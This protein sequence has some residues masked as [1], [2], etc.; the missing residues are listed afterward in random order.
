MKN[1]RWKKVF[2]YSYFTVLHLLAIVAV[3]L[4]G[5]AVAAKLKWTNVSGN[6]D[7][8][9][10]YFAKTANKYG[11]N[12]ATDSVTTAKRTSL[13]YQSIGVL[14]KYYPYNARV[15]IEEY[16]RSKNPTIAL[17]MLDAINLKLKGDKAYQAEMA[18][19]KSVTGKTAKSAFPWVNNDQWKTFRK[20]IKTDKKTI[21]SVSYITGVESRL[22][23]MCL[24]GE[25]VRMF[26]SKRE[27]FKQL[28]V[29]FNRVLLDKDRGYGVTGILASTA[30]NIERN[31]YNKK[32]PFYAGDYY[33]QCL[34]I[35][36]SVP[37]TSEKDSLNFQ[38]YYTIKRLTIGGHHYF[39]Y[40]YAALFLRQF[41]TQWLNAGYNLAYRPEVVA[42]LYNLGY[43]KSKP[44]P[45]PQVGGS[46]FNVD[47]QPYTFGGLCYEFYYS[48]ELADL[49]PLTNEPFIPTDVLEK[50]VKFTRKG[51]VYLP[52]PSASLFQEKFTL[53]KDTVNAKK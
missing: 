25:Q 39:D 38:K 1:N 26:N 43:Q 29:P 51:D 3:V 15:I 6:V 31:V 35:N 14:A 47:G 12:V 20:V 41:Y 13:M 37:I 32:S 19:L 9:N 49:F 34:P 11:N 40:L 7:L 5:I 18:Q 33:R 30:F 10:R 2:K 23:V 50:T 17:R 36:D 46:D 4:I 52:L 8:N 21:D 42:T 27:K 28:V 16:D 53:K 48:G 45:N 44:N 22:I 24:V